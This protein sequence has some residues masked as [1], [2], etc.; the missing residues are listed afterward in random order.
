MEKPE[1]GVYVAKVT[2]DTVKTFHADENAVSD[3][4]TTRIFTARDE[5]RASQEKARA[6]KL[7]VEEEHRRR[8]DRETLKKKRQRWFMVKDCATLLGTAAL[9]YCTY[10]FGQLVAIGSIVGCIVAA[11]CRI[12]NYIE[13]E[14][15]NV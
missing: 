11:G 10:R 14:N 12:T 1:N 7:R 15:Q 3:A 5:A 4:Q 2:D 8:T 9:I 13:K 6:D